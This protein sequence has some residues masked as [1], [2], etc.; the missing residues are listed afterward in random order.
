M[1]CNIMSAMVHEKSGRRD[2]ACKLM[3]RE[4]R[5]LKVQVEACLPELNSLSHMRITS[6]MTVIIPETFEIA[7]ALFLRCM[8]RRAQIEFGHIPIHW[9]GATCLL[10]ACKYM[11]SS[12]PSLEALY[13]FLKGRRHGFHFLD[14]VTRLKIATTEVRILR[15]VEYRVRWG[16]QDPFY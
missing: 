6:I 3:P 7:S 9:I 2:G 16:K 12:C 4:H 1:A 14:T 5:L 8:G 10:I 13:W 15:A 11:E